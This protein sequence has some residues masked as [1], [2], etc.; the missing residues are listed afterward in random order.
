MYTVSAPRRMALR[1]ASMATLPPPTT[2]TFLPVRMGVL[3]VGRYA[4]IRLERVRNSLAE[5]TPF[6]LSPGMPMNRG[7]PAPEPTNTAS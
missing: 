4:F 5:Y 3:L 1:A 6:R 7:R 2:A